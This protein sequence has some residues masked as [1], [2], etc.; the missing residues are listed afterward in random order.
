M[1]YV[2]LSS[3]YALGYPSGLGLGLEIKLGLE[4]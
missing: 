3:F 1:K 2:I 4:L